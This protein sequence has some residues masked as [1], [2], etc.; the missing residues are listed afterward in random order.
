MQFEWA[1]KHVM[2]RNAGGIKNRMNK[3]YRLFEKERW[4]SKSPL[5]VDIPLV[6]TYFIDLEYI[7]PQLPPYVTMVC[8]LNIDE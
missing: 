2:P 1:L 8:D 6:V 7:P 5:A 4:T 3:L